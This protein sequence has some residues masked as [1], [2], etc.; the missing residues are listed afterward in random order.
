MPATPNIRYIDTRGLSGAPVPFTQVV[1]NGMAHGGGLYVPTEIPQLNLN[2]ILALSN[3]GYA[4]RA[5]AIYKIFG[6]DLPTGDIDSLMND[7]YGAQW[8]TTDI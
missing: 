1:V 5:A 4:E 8:D 6:V 2:Q 7:A 3:M